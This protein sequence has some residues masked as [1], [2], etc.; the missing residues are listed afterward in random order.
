MRVYIETN[1]FYHNFQ[2]IYVFYATE[3]FSQSVIETVN[4]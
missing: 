4:F 3:N 1:A 2:F